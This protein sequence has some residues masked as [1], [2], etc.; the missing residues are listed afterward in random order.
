MASSHALTA[1]D[2]SCVISL[3]MISRLEEEK[4]L[5]S[6]DFKQTLPVVVHAHQAAIVKHALRIQKPGLSFNSYG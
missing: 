1:V 2:H 5:K 6:G 4:L 3:A